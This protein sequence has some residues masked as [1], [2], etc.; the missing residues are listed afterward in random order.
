MAEL[1]ARTFDLLKRRHVVPYIDAELHLLHC[2]GRKTSHVGGEFSSH[3]PSAS[4]T[5]SGAGQQQPSW[6]DTI[7]TKLYTCLIAALASQPRFLSVTLAQDDPPSLLL[8]KALLP[9]FGDS[10][11]GDTEG[12][13]VPIFLDLV[14][15]PFE[16]T[17]I[18]SGVAGKLVS[19][20]RLEETPEL[21]Y[22]STSKAGAVILASMHADRALDILKP[23]AASG[24]SWIMES[25]PRCGTKVRLVHDW[26]G[27]CVVV[28]QK[29]SS[30]GRIAYVS[31]AHRLLKMR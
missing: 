25:G 13:L 7:D 8:D 31:L 5:Y 11:V 18:V 19:E 22:L 14:N 29:F 12:D 17:G 28:V 20:M 24:L 2:S 21:S 6:V 26:G 4:R 16:A 15:L 1:Q 23:A 9:I 30:F 10:L 27:I 3:R